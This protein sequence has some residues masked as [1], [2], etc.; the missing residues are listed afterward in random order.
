MSE[1]KKKLAKGPLQRIPT[2]SLVASIRRD[3]KKKMKDS[4]PDKPSR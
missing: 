3:L 1:Q 2:R 4:N